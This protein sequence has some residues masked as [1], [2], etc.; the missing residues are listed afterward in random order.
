[1]F[2]EQARYNYSSS[3]QRSETDL[4]TQPETLRSAGARVVHA[5]GFYKHL[6]PLE[7]GR[8]LVAAEAALCLC[9]KSPENVHHRDTENAEIAQRKPKLRHHLLIEKIERYVV[10]S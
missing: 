5:I 10:E 3:L 2:I 4:R 1:M 8:Y 7:P 6:A 9:G